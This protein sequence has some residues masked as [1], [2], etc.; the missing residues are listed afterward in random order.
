MGPKNFSITFHI[1]VKMTRV[2]VCKAVCVVW[3]VGMS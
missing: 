2:V 3:N 1:N